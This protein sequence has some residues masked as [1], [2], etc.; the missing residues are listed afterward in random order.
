MVLD[1]TQFVNIGEIYREHGVGGACRFYSYSGDDRNLKAGK[2]FVLENSH[3]ETVEVKIKKISP[4]GKQFLIHFDAFQTPEE[5][6]YWRKAKLWFDKKNLTRK[7]GEVYD[8]EW[9]G[10]RLAAKDGTIL[11]T[12]LGID[13]TP[14][15]QFILEVNGKK[16]LV[17]FVADWM[18]DADFDKMILTMNLPDGLI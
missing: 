16:I 3:G 8:F 12:V 17:P 5:V 1:K 7:K 9:Q 15:K 14:L 10:M 6:S 13:Y 2:N 4:Y 11:G 18:I